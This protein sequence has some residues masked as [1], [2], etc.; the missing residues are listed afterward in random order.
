MLIFRVRLERCKVRFIR[1][2]P[3]PGVE[4]AATLGDEAALSTPVARHR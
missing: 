1:R 3:L 4:R 2:I